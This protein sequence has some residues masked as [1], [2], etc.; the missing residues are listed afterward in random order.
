MHAFL[1]ALLA[2]A[3][4]QAAHA[5][6]LVGGRFVE[7]DGW[8]ARITLDCLL[9]DKLCGSFR[10]ETLDCEGDL[11]YIGETATGFEFRTELRA[12]RCLP[13]CT[14]QVSGDFKRYAE[15]CKDSRHEGSLTAANA[16]TAAPAPAPETARVASTPRAAPTSKLTGQVHYKWDNGD[17]FDGQMLDGKRNGKG[18]FVWASGQSYDGDWRDD[19][20]VGEG[21]MVFVNGDRFQGQVKDGKPDGRGKMQFSNGD[22]YEG[23]FDKGISDGEGVYTEKDGSR[24][25]GQW[26]TGFKSGHGTYV[27]AYGQ[28]YEGKWVADRA[29]GKGTI[30][31]SNGDRY[32]G[33]VSNGMAQGKGVRITASQDRYEGDFAQ[34][35]AQGEG[36]YRWNNGEVYTGSW[37]KGKKVGKGRYTWANGDYWEGEFADDKKTEAGRQYFTPTLVAA[38]PEATNLARQADALAGPADANAGRA[39]AARTDEKSPDR[40]KLLAIPMVAKELRDCMRKLGSDCAA[41]VINDV[42]SDTLQA[43][44]WQ[45]MATEKGARDKG[46]VFEV[47]ANSVLEGGDVFS[48]LRSGD[49]N[50]ARNIG[51]KYAC[52][53]Q[54]LEIQ[55]VYNCMGGQT[56]KLDPNIDKYAGKVISATDI[57]SWFKDACER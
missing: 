57:R 46:P 14:V 16:A 39:Q 23:Q 7:T 53:P 48:W 5:A 11:I 38:T 2:F 22:T 34:G 42:L 31:F 51:I 33:P 1:V 15:V 24:Y 47:D 36:V 13:A 54:T 44:K 27:W 20:A 17:V 6:A 37:Q 40:A 26:K 43:H 25:T 52:R 56:C 49:G 19:V 12:G 45:A 18:R 35:E 29:E 50:R 10:Y 32:D 21:A 30:V 8:K 55:L 4:I 3:G 9:K 28:R 41:R